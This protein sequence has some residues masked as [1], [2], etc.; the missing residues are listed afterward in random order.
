MDSSGGATIGNWTE[1]VEDLVQSGE[2]DRA[3]SFLESVISNLENELEKEQLQNKN[4]EKFG[5]CT[6]DRL[7]TALQDL[8]RLYAAQGL[9]LRADQTQSRALQIKHRKL[10]RDELSIFLGES[11]PTHVKISHMRELGARKGSSSNENAEDRISQ[12]GATTLDG[13]A[14][15]GLSESSSNLHSDGIQ[16][17][18]GGDDDWEAIAD[19][20]PEELLSPQCLPGIS[21]LSL[22][23]SKSQQTKRRG[24]G[25]FAYKKQGL[26]SDNPSDEPIIDDDSEDNSVGH[27][28]DAEKRNLLYGTRHVLVL[29]DFPPSTRTTDLEKLLNKF[30]DLF[31]IRWV[32]DTTAIV[33]FRTPAAALEARN[34][35]ECPFTVR[36]LEEDDELLSSIPPKAH[37]SV[38]NNLTVILET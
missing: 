32:N 18:S 5:S 17:D 4:G 37:P 22:E 25:T 1:M 28:E 24:R 10:L 11:H 26:Y 16:H 12:D 19:R 3:V 8:S 29:A 27:A 35:I 38:K 36:A 20:A 9:P 14:E 15:D 34:S 33:V 13:I 2:I 6:A 7:C 30:K 21:K 31:V 23:E